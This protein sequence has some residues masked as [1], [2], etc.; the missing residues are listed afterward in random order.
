MK[1]PEEASRSV[2]SVIEPPERTNVLPPVIEI[3]WTVSVLA[4][5]ETVSPVP[6]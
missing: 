1:L 4:L 6:I 5:C 3:L 2:L